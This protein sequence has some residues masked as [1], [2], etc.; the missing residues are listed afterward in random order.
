M[1]RVRQTVVN[2]NCADSHEGT[3]ERREGGSPHGSQL[4]FIQEQTRDSG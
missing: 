1:E 2:G 3:Q 4:L